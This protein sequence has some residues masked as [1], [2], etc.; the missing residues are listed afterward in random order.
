MDYDRRLKISSGGMG[1]ISFDPL[2]LKETNFNIL[3]PPN[4]FAD[5]INLTITFQTPNGEI[6]KTAKELSS[7]E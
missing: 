2:G 3:I 1:V 7:L 6:T 5:N 4:F